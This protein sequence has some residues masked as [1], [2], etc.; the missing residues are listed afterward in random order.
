MKNFYRRKTN[1]IAIFDDLKK[2]S[3]LK[4]KTILNQKYNHS[5]GLQYIRR[6]PKR[7][8]LRTAQWSNRSFLTLFFTFGCVIRQNAVAF[9]FLVELMKKRRRHYRFM[10]SPP[11][12]AETNHLWWKKWRPDELW[13]LMKIFV[14]LFRFFATWNVFDYLNRTNS[15]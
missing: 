6:R 9:Y 11:F 4:K 13:R 8:I 15:V 10:R 14:C 1:I 3:D 2:F 5:S 7:E 12:S